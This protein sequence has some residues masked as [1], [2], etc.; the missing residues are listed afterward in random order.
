MVEG[1][2]QFLTKGIDN[3]GKFLLTIFYHFEIMKKRGV[4]CTDWVYA[5]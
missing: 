5:S 2:K 4:L 1:K 3:E